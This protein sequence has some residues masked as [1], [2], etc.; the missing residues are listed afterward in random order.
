MHLANTIQL[1]YGIPGIITY[2][3]VIYAMHGVEKILNKSFIRIYTL[4]AAINIATWLSSWLS[5]RLR[6]EPTFFFYYEWASDHNLFRNILNFLVIHFY[7]AQNVCVLLLSF[8]RYAAIY[9]ISKDMLWWK[10]YHLIIAASAH[11]LCLILILS[12]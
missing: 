9:S 3:I 5:H 12:T 6:D 11:I 4:T 1:A 2:F 8:D 10:K 7:S